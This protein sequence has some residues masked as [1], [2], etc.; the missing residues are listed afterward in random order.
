MLFYEYILLVVSQFPNGMLNIVQSPVGS[1]LV[2]G[3]KASKMLTDEA[4]RCHP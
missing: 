1:Q 4:F 2:F 3:L